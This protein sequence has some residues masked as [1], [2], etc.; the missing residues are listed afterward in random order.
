MIEN[1]YFGSGGI[2]GTIEYFGKIKYLL[3]AGVC[4]TQ[5]DIYGC[6]AGSFA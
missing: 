6:S 4:D 3:T 1:I 5:T 2:T